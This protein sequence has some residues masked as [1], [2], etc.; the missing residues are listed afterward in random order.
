[1]TEVMLN[2]CKGIGVEGSHQRWTTYLYSGRCC[3]L[4]SLEALCLVVASKIASF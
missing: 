2:N 1:M 3:L 4:L